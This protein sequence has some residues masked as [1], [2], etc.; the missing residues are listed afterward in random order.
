MQVVQEFTNA[1][2]RLS[3]GVLRRSS[4]GEC[5]DP[6]LQ[7]FAAKIKG[8]IAAWKIARQQGINSSILFLQNAVS[9]V[10]NCPTTDVFT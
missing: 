1:K 10:G 2:S 8:E 6:P 7:E 4:Q 3:K 5:V 9:F